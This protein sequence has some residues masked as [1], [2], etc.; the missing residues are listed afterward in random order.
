MGSSFEFDVA[1]KSPDFLGFDLMGSF[2]FNADRG[3]GVDTEVDSRTTW[4][5]E[6]ADQ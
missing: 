5:V 1:C 6:G 3:V 4:A 2:A